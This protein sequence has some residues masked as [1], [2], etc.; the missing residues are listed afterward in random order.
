VE[1]RLAVQRTA[2]AIADAAIGAHVA[3]GDAGQILQDAGD[4][5]CPTAPHHRI[6]WPR[7]WPHPGPDEPYPIDPELA[8][9]TVQVEAAL[10]FGSYASAI[11]DERLGTAF[12]EL[13]D[14]LVGAALEAPAP[15]MAVSG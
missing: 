13:S 9:P 5:W 4:D 3:G 11:A 15:R 6:P 7:H 14:R 8:A 2:R 12:A 10:V 1:L